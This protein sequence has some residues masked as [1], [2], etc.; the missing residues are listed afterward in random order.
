MYNLPNETLN[1]LNNKLIVEV[2]FCNL[3]KAF[4]SVDR[5]ILLSKLEYYEIT[6]IIN[7]FYKSYLHD[8]C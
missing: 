7:A 1:V 4:T 6:H 2:I 5:D 3:Q 8:T